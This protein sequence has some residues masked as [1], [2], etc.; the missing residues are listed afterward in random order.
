MPTK[1]GREENPETQKRHTSELLIWPLCLNWSKNGTMTLFSAVKIPPAPSSS[2]GNVN[3]EISNSPHPPNLDFRVPVTYSLQCF[4]NQKK[5]TI[6]GT[7]FEKWRNFKKAQGKGEE[8]DRRKISWQLIGTMPGFDPYPTMEYDFPA[9]VC[10]YAN[11]QQWYLNS[12]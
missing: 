12:F 2:I 11:R 3:W 5:W 1:Y 8:T 4:G 6:F 9:P 7:I 10:P